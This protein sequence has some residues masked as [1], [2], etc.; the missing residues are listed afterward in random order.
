MFY[1]RNADLNHVVISVLKSILG[2]ESKC[3]EWEIYNVNSVSQYVNLVQ[4]SL[5]KL[6]YGLF[7]VSWPEAFGSD[8]EI[9]ELFS[10]TSKQKQ[11]FQAP[12]VRRSKIRSTGS[13]IFHSRKMEFE[14]IQKTIGNRELEAICFLVSWKWA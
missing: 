7:C 14:S 4:F 1:A 6:W 10:D 9:P 2:E 8:K 5:G 3:W 12:T 13:G 11:V